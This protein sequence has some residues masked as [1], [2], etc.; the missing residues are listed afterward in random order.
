MSDD[1][2]RMIDEEAALANCESEAV[3]IP[4]RVQSF[5][6]VLGFDRKTMMLRYCSDNVTK[7]FPGQ[8]EPQDG[9]DLRSFGDDSSFSHAIRG[10]LG[11]PTI[12]TQRDRVGVFQ[13][14]GV[15]TDVSVFANNDT[16]VVDLEPMTKPSGRNTPGLQMVRSML[17]GVETGRGVDRLLESAVKALRHLTGFDR[18]MAYRFFPNLDGEVVAEAKGPRAEPYLG[19]RYP[20]SDIPPQ[21]RQL[22][23]RSTVRIIADI[24]DPHSTLLTFGSDTPLD[25]S[26]SHLR[27]CSPIHA[28]YLRNM[29]VASSMNTSLVVGGE[30]WGLFAL[31]HFRGKYPSPDV[32]AVAE[33]FGQLISIQIQQELEREASARNEQISL[34]IDR[35]EPENSSLENFIDLHAATLCKLADWDGLAVVHHETIVTNGDT[36]TNDAIKTICGLSDDES[37]ILSSLLLTGRFDYPDLGK[38]AG[39]MVQRFG[40]DCFLLFFRNEVQHE[41]RWAGLPEKEIELGPDGPHLRPRASFAEYRESVIGKSRD[42]TRVDEAVA[43]KVGSLLVSFAFSD[44][45][46]LQKEWTRTKYTQDLMIAELNHRVRNTL[47]L[48]QS[49]AKQNTTSAESVEQYVETLEK[50]ITALS[51]AHDLVGASGLQYAALR[52]LISGELKPY[53]GSQAKITVKGEPI[54]VRPDIAPIISLVIH[55]MASNAAKYGAFA[56]EGNSLSVRWE[57]DA[58]GVSLEWIEECSTPRLPPAHRGFGLSLIERAIPHQCDGKSK[59]T[60]EGNTLRIDLWLP[61]KVVVHLPSHEGGPTPALPEATKSPGAG[62]ERALLLEDNIVLAFEMEKLL[63]ANGVARV[64]VH[65]R[66]EEARGAIQKNRYEVAVCDINLGEQTSFEIA[67]ELL[68]DKVPVIF[69]TGY[70]NRIEMPEQLKRIPLLVKP[71]KGQELQQTLASI[72][73]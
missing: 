65:G 30:L 3:H 2:S 56:P 11:L 38:T 18:V 17:S 70:D 35:V 9:F 15:A 14:G 12:E 71:I 7:L 24:D 58:T 36:P 72:R 64:D 45:A 39:V 52:D 59:I 25:L 8:A 10:S 41:L 4:G 57:Q 23:V 33:L 19:L 47:A 55:E 26:L 16:F 66:V 61:D 29:G 32:R 54:A 1:Y 48:V 42:W 50:R 73:V 31:H 68:R 37:T 63:K 34:L 21:V 20:A 44:S 40:Q 43:R 22:M 60:Y 6:V 27:G 69:V 46:T 53:R 51:Q 62:F 5:G 13:F 67:S 49:I 28:V